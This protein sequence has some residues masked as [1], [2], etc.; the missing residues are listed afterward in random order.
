MK[1]L[2]S[3]LLALVMCLSLVACGGG[4]DVQPAIDAY[5]QCSETY[6]KFVEIGNAHLE[7][8]T[9]EDIAFLNGCADVLNEY[10]EKLESETEFTQEE[11]DEMVEMFDEF[12]GI[13]E[14]FL[15][16]YE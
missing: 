10:A 6:N 7:D 1:K 15:A 8:F 5:N 2:I 14:E 12:N 13:I 9:E 16:I 11:I 3:L 4:P